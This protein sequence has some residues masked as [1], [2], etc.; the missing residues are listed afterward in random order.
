MQIYQLKNLLNLAD[1]VRSTFYYYLKTKDQDKYMLDDII[2]E[3]K[4]L[5]SKY[6]NI[7][8]MGGSSHVNE[9]EVIE[10]KIPKY[11]ETHN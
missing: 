2:K 1:L 4:I 6:E 3:Y 5:Q 7:I 10:M 11:I 9:L 8:I